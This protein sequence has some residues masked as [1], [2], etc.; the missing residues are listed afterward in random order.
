MVQLKRFH[1]FQKFFQKTNKFS[2]HDEYLL[3]STCRCPIRK[4]VSNSL[5]V[6]LEFTRLQ[7]LFTVLDRLVRYMEPV[8]KVILRYIRALRHFQEIRSRPP[9]IHRRF[10]Q[11]G[12]P[13]E[14]FQE[15]STDYTAQPC[16]LYWTN[17]FV[18]YVC[19]QCRTDAIKTP[20]SFKTN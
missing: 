1:V 7:N 4:R 20:V 11:L 2:G 10:A 18:T 16:C 19:L 17:G 3:I 12:V 14:N 15:T 9:E 8:A 13:F 5:G 6:W